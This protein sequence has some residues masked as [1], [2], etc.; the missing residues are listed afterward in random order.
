MRVV[1]CAVEKFTALSLIVV[2]ASLYSSSFPSPYVDALSLPGRQIIRRHESPRLRELKY[3]DHDDDLQNI[4]ESEKRPI[5]RGI[6]RWK[7]RKSL[8]KALF[9][10]EEEVIWQDNF[11]PDDNY[12]Q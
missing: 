2:L 11:M 5:R 1:T 6:F 10:L 8:S 9:P 3:R 12:F 4:I 7:K